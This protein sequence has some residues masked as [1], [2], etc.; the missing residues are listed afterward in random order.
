M[1]LNLNEIKK[2]LLNFFKKEDIDYLLTKFTPSGEIAKKGEN[3]TL[4][5]YNP[6]LIQIIDYSLINLEED[7]F[8]ELL[9]LLGEYFLFHGDLNSAKSVF[10]FSHEYSV[11]RSHLFVYS[12]YSLLS[13]GDI[14]SRHAEWKSSIYYIQEAKKCFKKQKDYVGMARCENLMGTILGDKGKLD[15]ALEHFEKSLSYLNI[16]SDDTLSGMIE[17]NLGI[18][19]SILGKFDIAYTY[20]QRALF[21]FQSFNDI[22]RIVEVKNN[23]ALYYTFKKD[24]LTALETFDESIKMSTTDKLIYSLGIA[25]AGK[26]YIHTVLKDLPAASA[27]AD[28]AREISESI[29][30]KLT[31]ADVYKIMGIIERDKKNY[32]AAIKFFELSLNL[33]KELKNTLNEAETLM[34]YG[35]LYVMQ[36]DK[37][38]LQFFKKSLIKFKLINSSFMIKKV[39]GLIK[40]F[41]QKTTSKIL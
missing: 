27:Y 26:A 17:I 4:L 18:I 25:Y 32:E 3:V 40:D 12:S 39:N 14:Y 41:T 22:Q 1:P 21:V 33:N 23:L 30:D 31:L 9:N 6:T 11:K 2:I 29:N 19:Y 35:T 20:Y 16:H 38:A 37:K 15:K 36:N 7:K 34:E 5:D 24:F 8:L 10:L 13:L 28:K